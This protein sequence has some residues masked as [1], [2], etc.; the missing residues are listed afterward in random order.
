[1]KNFA[2]IALLAFG[3]SV[4]AIACEN[5]PKEESTATTVDTTQQTQ[6]QAEQTP[7]ATDSTA[8]PAEAPAEVK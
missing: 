6:V 1:M 2:K 4:V 3:V 5:K 8:K 7:M